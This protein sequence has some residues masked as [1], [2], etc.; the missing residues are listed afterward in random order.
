MI[1]YAICDKVANAVS[2]HRA[3]EGDAW[4]KERDARA[5]AESA[6]ALCRNWLYKRGELEEFLRAGN[7]LMFITSEL[8]CAKG[9]SR[10]IH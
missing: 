6:W 7:Y 9:D 8:S 2:F 4:A 10:E 3:A 5:R 1:E